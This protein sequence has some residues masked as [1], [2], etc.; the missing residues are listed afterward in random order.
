MEDKL[1]VGIDL[2][3]IMT[4]VRCANLEKDWNISTVLCKKKQEDSWYIGKEAYQCVLQGEGSLKDHL[5]SL[6][7]RED[8]AVFE[9][10]C[11]T[12]E[13]LLSTFFSELFSMLKRETKKEKIG[14]VML[15]LDYIETS[16]LN[17]IRSCV[18][19]AGVEESLVHIISREEA[20]LYYIMS[21]RREIW[22]HEVG[23]FELTKAGFHYFHLQ[24]KRSLKE[25]TVFADSVCLEEN[26]RVEELAGT[27]G[28]KLGDQMVA[29]YAE[30]MLHGR[31][32]SAVILTGEF[33]MRTD[34]APSFM[35]IIGEKRRV[36]QD[37]NL[38][39]QGCL[40]KAAEILR[41]QRDSGFTCI[42]QGRLDVSVSVDVLFGG[43]EKRLVMVPLGAV[44]YE[45]DA[46]AEFILDE[47]REVAF[48]IASA[49]TGQQEKKSFL[50]LEGF[51][52]RP[53]KTTRV[54]MALRFLDAKTMEVTIRDLGFGELFAASDTVI[55]Q[56]VML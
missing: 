16:F 7:K 11:Y 35:Q 28:K 17:R 23:L 1:M 48:L 21:Q 49:H 39:A 50:S 55:R 15:C 25:L 46:R 18:T 53:P 20:F 13:E 31:L 56:E 40:S 19:K 51:P 12:G 42:C 32:F 4:Q 3:D 6:V 54:E 24:V 2:G 8:R 26:F 52:N 36:Y 44:W 38:F 47:E 14:C 5:L 29:A 43:K 45:T 30:R 9:G 34:W 33:F 22:N 27:S 37:S 10:K 41:G